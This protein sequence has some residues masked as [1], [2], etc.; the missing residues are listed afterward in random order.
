MM[1]GTRKD[2]PSKAILVP[3]IHTAN[4]PQPLKKIRKSR[5]L[6]SLAKELP[7]ADEKAV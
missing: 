1:G 4:N 6:M 3:K 2:L 7:T 5:A